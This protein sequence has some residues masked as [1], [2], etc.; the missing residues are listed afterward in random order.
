MSKINL[1]IIIPT[2]NSYKIIGKLIS[3]LKQQKFKEWNV[4][5]VDGQSKKKHKSY[6]KNV[7]RQDKRFKYV[8]QKNNTKGIYDAMSYGMKIVDPRHWIIFMGSDDYF[9]NK[10][11]I[12]KLIEVL[13]EK[14][15]KYDI[16]DVLF[17]RCVYINNNKRIRVS[18]FS[19]NSFSRIYTNI[20]I[21]KKLFWG[22][23]PPHQ[24]TVLSPSVRKINQKF[25]NEYKLAADLDYLLELSKKSNI[26]FK[27][28]SIELSNLGSNGVSN[29]ETFQR[30]FEV[31]KVYFK[32][33]KLLFIIPFFS[34]YIK[35][36]LSK[37]TKT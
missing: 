31:I 33:F 24:G 19:E 18:S 37:F 12:S 36:I 21:R 20:E 22:S 10:L 23:S 6:L 7:C 26:R 9:P 2:L 34:R 29:K 14:N 4:L 5:F 28:S 13:E 15:N 16:F 17:C 11:S 35:R 8:H 27:S 1:T 3:S 30:L 25:S 32:Y